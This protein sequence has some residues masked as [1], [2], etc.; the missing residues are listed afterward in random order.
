MAQNASNTVFPYLLNGASSD[1]CVNGSVT[2]VDFKYTVPSGKQFVFQRLM[3]YMDDA[4]VFDALKF[5]SLT[6]LTNGVKMSVGGVELVTWK[7]MIDIVTTMY[8]LAP[9]AHLARENKG[10]AGRWTMSKSYG[11]SLLVQ[12]GET[13]SALVQD[14]LG[15]L[16]TMNIRIHGYLRE[17]VSGST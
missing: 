6:A 13:V 14:N 9:Y 12:T 8:D 2:P 17:T 7:N 11:D 5:G 15:D 16:D 1:M 3:L 10:C 4:S